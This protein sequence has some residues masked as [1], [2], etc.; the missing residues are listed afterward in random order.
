MSPRPNLITSDARVPSESATWAV[1]R[2]TS[3]RPTVAAATSRVPY[4]QFFDQYPVAWLSSS[5]RQGCNGL[6]RHKAIHEGASHFH[7]KLDMK[8]ICLLPPMTLRLLQE[9]FQFALLRYEM[10]NL[11]ANRVFDLFDVKCNGVIEFGEFV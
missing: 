9:E 1:R 11:F 6:C 8:Q 7:H 2:L 4:V 3:K 10:Q 5:N